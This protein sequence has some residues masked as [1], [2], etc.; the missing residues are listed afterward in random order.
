MKISKKFL[1]VGLLIAAVSILVTIWELTSVMAEPIFKP[2]P[3]PTPEVLASGWYRFTDPDAGYSIS[4]PPNSFLS[5]SE[6][7]ALEF[8][9][10]AITFPISEGR[11]YWRMQI[12]VY[13]NNE[14][15]SFQQFVEEKVYNGKSPKKGNDIPLTPTKF[16]GF[17]AAKMTML[18]FDQA[19]FIS[20]K[21]KIYFISLS[22]DMQSGNSP[23]PEAVEIY[24]NIL[25][26]L[27]IK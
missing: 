11:N 13:T 7:I 17:D 22:Y 27:S 24:N 18:P 9:Q 19:M 16:T 4:Y 25:D 1:I 2:K 14:R 21:N 26:T 15:L 8:K 5:V 6:D 12:I 3:S 23:T 20:A 10:V